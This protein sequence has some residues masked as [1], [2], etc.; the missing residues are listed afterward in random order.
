MT[1]L[2][3][4]VQDIKKDSDARISSI[5]EETRKG[6]DKINKEAENEAAEKCAEIN[7]RAKEQAEA[8][9]ERALSAA[10]LQ[11]RREILSAKQKIISGI[12]ENAKKSIYKLPDKEY[13]NIILKMIRKYAPK[14]DGKILFSKADKNRLPDGFAKAVEAAAKEKGAKLAISDET[15]AIDGGFVLSY[16]GI[17][18]NCS[19]EALFDA[20]HDELQDKVNKILFSGG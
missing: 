1:G 2:D 10:A 17:E 12:I 8:V 19:F 15:R 7:R 11:Q 3:K 6:K 13:F 9:K 20:K 4:I 14:A 16:G 5:M 18:E